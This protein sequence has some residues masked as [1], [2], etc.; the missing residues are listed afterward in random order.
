[1]GATNLNFTAAVQGAVRA[2]LARRG[3]DGVTLCAPLG[4]S[5]N[6]IYARLNGTKPFNTDEIEATTK[7]LG[8]TVDQ[9]IRSAALSD[10]VQRVAS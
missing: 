9:L 7:F 4:L 10:V 8:I 3:L 6:S 2:E 5:R 1:M